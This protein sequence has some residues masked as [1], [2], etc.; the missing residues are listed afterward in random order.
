MF[1]TA[2]LDVGTVGEVKV[3]QITEAAFNAMTSSGE[4][5]LDFHIYKLS[6]LNF[7]LGKQPNG[8]GQFIF[9]KVNPGAGGTLFTVDYSAL[10]VADKED[11]E[12]VFRETFTPD[13][14][15]ER[16]P[17]DRKSIIV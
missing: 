17:G 6:F 10:T 14:L 12:M 16:R 4:A 1:Y 8:P 3:E 15:E 7:L 2:F 9:G 5:P 11:G 13:M